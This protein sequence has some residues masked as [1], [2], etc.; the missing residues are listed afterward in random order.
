MQML[1]PMRVFCSLLSVSRLPWHQL[2]ITE[3]GMDMYDG[4][5]ELCWLGSDKMRSW[6][7]QNSLLPF[8]HREAR[9]FQTLSGRPSGGRPSGSLIHSAPAGTTRVRFAD[10]DLPSMRASR[11]ASVP[12]ASSDGSQYSAIV[13]DA[14]A[15][16]AASSKGHIQSSALNP[17]LLCEYQL[18]CLLLSSLIDV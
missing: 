11:T 2:P 13:A 9:L 10:Q 6:G 17:Q 7:L 14:A 1:R 16:T 5:S 8:L 18:P 12:T 4:T 3:K 15:A